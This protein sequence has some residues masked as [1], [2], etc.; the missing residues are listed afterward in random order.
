MSEG[1]QTF[2]LQ[3][4]AIQEFELKD[5]KELLNKLKSWTFE[6]DENIIKNLDKDDNSISETE[7]KLYEQSKESLDMISFLKWVIVS[8]EKKE[9]NKTNYW[10]T[11]WALNNNTLKIDKPKINNEPWKKLKEIT[12]NYK[13]FED[14]K[15]DSIWRKKILEIDASWLNMCPSSNFKDWKNQ[16]LENIKEKLAEIETN[17]IKW[18]LEWLVDEKQQEK[19]LTWTC[20]S[21][22]LINLLMEKWFSEKEAL[23]LTSNNILS[24][25]VKNSIKI[26]NLL[27]EKITINEILNQENSEERIKFLKNKWFNKNTINEILN[28][29]SEKINLNNQKI[30]VQNILSFWLEWY[31]YF[32]NEYYLKNTSETIKISDKKKFLE[33]SK[34]L[35]ENNKPINFYNLSNPSF[36]DDFNLIKNFQKISWKKLNYFDTKDINLSELTNKEK[37]ELLEIVDEEN[38]KTILVENQ[39]EIRKLDKKKYLNQLNTILNN[40]SLSEDLENEEDN[41]RIDNTL[42]KLFKEDYK[43]AIEI[44]EDIDFWTGKL[45]ELPKTKEIIFKNPEVINY[46]IKENFKFYKILPQNLQKEH[47][48]QYTE[49]VL[50]N[51]DYKDI[52]L[53]KL[54]FWNLKDL[55]IIFNT[56]NKY[57][58]ENSINIINNLIKRPIF[59]LTLI[60]FQKDHYNEMNS[61]NEEQKKEIWKILDL[62]WKYWEEKKLKYKKT[63]NKVSN[64]NIIKSKVWTKEYDNEYSLQLGSLQNKVYNKSLLLLEKYSSN[65]EKQG[66]LASIINKLT[67]KILSNS[68]YPTDLISKL[69]YLIDEKEYNFILENIEISG[70]ELSEE[71]IEKSNNKINNILEKNPNDKKSIEKLYL[72]RKWKFNDKAYTLIYN[73][74]LENIVNTLEKQWENY[75]DIKW[76]LWKK[77][78]I[79]SEN[80]IQIITLNK[81]LWKNKISSELKN[82][83]I[84]IIKNVEIQKKSE[85]TKIFTNDWVYKTAKEWNDKQLNFLINKYK[86]EYK[87]NY[88][89]ELNR[90]INKYEK[91]YWK[92]N[93]KE[94]NNIN[95]EQK[96]NI[97]KNQNYSFLHETWVVTISENWKTEKITLTPAERLLVNQNPETLENIVDFYKT[98][99]RIWLS[100]FWTIKEELFQ[101]IW[102]KKWVWFKIDSDYLNE[103]EIKIFLNSVLKSIWEDE[104]SPVFKLDSFLSIIERKNNTQIWWKEAIVNNNLSETKLENKFFNKFVNRNS[105]II[106]FN[107][108]KFEQS[109]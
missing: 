48:I 89:I 6:V 24:K 43:K 94:I 30:T 77:W 72:L 26:R 29:L 47:S 88:I 59:K 31:N 85:E 17:I 71:N 5:V 64:K 80:E 52:Q 91:E 20:D 82:E 34:F 60:S 53:A 96:N 14:L 56:I 1:N 75:I 2:D 36:R 92:L 61:L 66:E 19:I 28:L 45:L 41:I 33:I 50:I 22:K 69:A 76:I 68:D 13:S 108:S 8:L 35:K 4:Q 42:S 95:L 57:E 93:I 11:F 107:F 44:F 39:K 7:K 102:N 73:I 106:W 21:E 18:K 46:F 105:W 100:K 55:I 25:N 27:Q 79:Y 109:I 65:Q 51:A 15:N 63:K 16:T 62:L 87:E 84:N 40:S 104:I 98:L 99:D 3:Q 97:I 37:I 12:S 58:K 74:W 101:T 83:L 81:L 54:Q 67:E 103:N 32:S 49:S 9:E 70:K 10:W 90:D 23:E 38:L 86:K 78:Y